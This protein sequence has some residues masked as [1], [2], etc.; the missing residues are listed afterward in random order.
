MYADRVIMVIRVV[1][2]NKN[3]LNLQSFMLKNRLGTRRRFKVL[4]NSRRSSLLVSTGDIRWNTA[5]PQIVG[6]VQNE[7]ASRLF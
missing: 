7:K 5:R 3:V 4:R 1:V 2:S 6:V